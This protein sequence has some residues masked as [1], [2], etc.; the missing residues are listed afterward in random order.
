MISQIRPWK[1]ETANR[2]DRMKR[3]PLAVMMLALASFA[4]G[5][6]TTPQTPANSAPPAGQQSS[7]QP[8]TAG[9]PAKRPPQA[10]TQAEFDDFNK[11]RAN[12]DAATL[13]KA[14][15]DFAT[16]YP[17]SELR[18]LLY[19]EAVGAYQQA[20]N[21]P[22][23]GEMGKKVLTIDPNQPEALMAVASDLIE[24]TRDSDI[25]KN[26]RYDE[27]T[28]DAEQAL[29]SID[30]DLSIAPGTPEDKI[31]A[32]K[33]LM[34]SNADS[35]LGTIQF[36]KENYPAA[37]DYYQKSISAYPSQPDSIVV[38][39]LALALDKQNK[40]AEALKAAN[41]AV[42]LTQENTTVGSYARKER[43]RLVQLTGG[44]PTPSS[45]GS[46]SAP[47]TPT[48]PSTPAAPTG[49]SPTPSPK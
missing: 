12:I 7:A 20:N 23:M 24:S 5:Q 4:F 49:T 48:S 28:K 6:Q 18:I 43:D 30:T 21:M 36:K 31:D 25:D 42:D 10:K 29:Q 34:R 40:Y 47:A 9:A 1:E 45:P 19:E 15:D 32:Y 17:D 11:A 38:L 8:G 37:V 35:L 27:A 2:G 3:A 41:Q 39:R 46:P 14:A 33:G 13:E 16:K 26:Q 44:V 22:K